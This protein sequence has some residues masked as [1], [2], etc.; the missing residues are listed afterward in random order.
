MSHYKSNVRDIE[1]NLFEVLGREEILGTDPYDEL[2]RET[3]SAILAEVNHLAK[4]KLAESFADGDGTLPIF[5]PKTHS[6]TVPED[7]KKSFRALMDSGDVATRVAG[8]AWRSGHSAIGS[9]G[10][11][12]TQHWVESI[13]S[14]LFGRSQVRVHV[15]GNGQR[16]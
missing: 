10:G 9:V 4:T 15:V 5:D 7:I 11:P 16:A 8:R 2:D 3:V 6:V 12:R 13:D 14:S 1:F